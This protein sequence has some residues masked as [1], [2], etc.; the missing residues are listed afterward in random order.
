[1]AS[2]WSFIQQ[3]QKNVT[4]YFHF[5]EG[6]IP[7]WC[8]AL[9]KETRPFLLQK[10]DQIFSL[11]IMEVPP[12]TNIAKDPVWFIQYQWLPK[13]ILAWNALL[14]YNFLL[15]SIPGLYQYKKIFYIFE[16]CIIFLGGL[17]KYIHHQKY[18]KQQWVLSTATEESIPRLFQAEKWLLEQLPPQTLI[19][20]YTEIKMLTR[21][22]DVQSQIQAKQGSLK[23]FWRIFLSA[24]PPASSLSFGIFHTLPSLLDT[25][26]EFFAQTIPKTLPTGSIAIKSLFEKPLFLP[27]SAVRNTELSLLQ[28]QRTHEAKTTQTP[29]AIEVLNIQVYYNL[30]LAAE[31]QTGAWLAAFFIYASR[32]DSTLPIYVESSENKLREKLPKIFKEMINQARMF[33]ESHQKD[34]NYVKIECEVLL[35]LLKKRLLLLNMIKHH[36]PEQQKEEVTESNIELKEMQST[37][38]K[39]TDIAETQPPD[40]VQAFKRTCMNNWQTIKSFF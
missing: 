38:K 39:H 4:H 26:I 28:K 23:E 35:L 29:R 31:S 32:Q 18:Y 6:H 30:H 33:Y 37:E 19:A 22:S 13:N 2:I 24:T 7:Q 21:P 3:T 8:C 5:S 34:N 15:L 9:P 16:I 25:F 12:L 36:L 10:I 40:P 27:Y 11:A 1:M 17:C 20:K 14:I